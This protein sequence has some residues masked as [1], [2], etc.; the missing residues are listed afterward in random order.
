MVGY[1]NGDYCKYNDNHLMT[2]IERATETSV[3]IKCTSDN[4]DY[5][6]YY[7]YNG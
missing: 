7:W 5:L 6:T 3:Y 1:I 2:G 4:K